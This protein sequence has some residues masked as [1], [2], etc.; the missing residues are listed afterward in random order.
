MR[1]NLEERISLAGTVVPG[2]K[3]EVFS[4]VTGLL[5]EVGVN[6]GDKVN[7]GD[8]LAMVR[9]DDSGLVSIESPLT[10]VIAKRSCIPG[11]MVVAVDRSAA[12]ALFTIVNTMATGMFVKKAKRRVPN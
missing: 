3:I 7:E 5:Q 8:V 12:K 10:G 4:T 11:D 9:G 2:A 6:V 1:G